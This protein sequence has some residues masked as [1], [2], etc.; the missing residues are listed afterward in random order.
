VTSIVPI[1]NGKFTMGNTNCCYSKFARPPAAGGDQRGGKKKKKRRKHNK[2]DGGGDAKTCRRGGAPS[3]QSA[4]DPSAPANTSSN[5]GKTT[6]SKADKPKKKPPWA[7]RR[8][9]TDLAKNFGTISDTWRDAAS[10]QS[11][12]AHLALTGEGLDSENRQMS[13]LRYAI[14]LE[15]YVELDQA[16]RVQKRPEPELKALVLGIR[17]HEEDFFGME[18][19]LRCID[20]GMRGQVL[21]NLRRVNKDGV[22]AGSWVYQPVYPRVLDKLNE[23]LGHFQNDNIR[24]IKKRQS[25]VTSSSS[26][27]SSK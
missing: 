17:D 6:K 18:R 25:S 1:S 12:T 2:D 24:M 27:D 14:F 21:S 11:F 15:L 23:L 26:S 19:C 16:E 5:A 8:M 22:P 20:K 9:S 7:S 10:W 13:F 3:S 4:G